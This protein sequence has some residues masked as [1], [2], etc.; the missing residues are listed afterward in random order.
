MKIGW[1]CGNDDWAYKHLTQ[2]LID[3]LNDMEHV[4]NKDGDCV[5]ALYIEQLVRKSFPQLSKTIL[6]L[7][8]NRW[9]QGQ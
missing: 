2:H 1:Y 5:I 8:G 3:E 9:W 4:E 7:D 6:H